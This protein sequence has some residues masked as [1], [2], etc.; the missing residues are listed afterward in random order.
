MS[1]IWLNMKMNWRIQLKKI[2]S[3]KERGE[4]P[5]LILTSRIR[6]QDGKEGGD[7]KRS[8]PITKS[9][10]ANMRG[11][12]ELDSLKRRN[13]IVLVMHLLCYAHYIISYIV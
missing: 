12:K 7:S 13:R 1:H 11:P 10:W 4:D 8:I 6:T 9:N 5:Y 2:L 3:Q